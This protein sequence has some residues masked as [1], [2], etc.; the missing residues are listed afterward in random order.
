MD[1]C[2]V[3]RLGIDVFNHDLDA[4]LVH[5]DSAGK[6]REYGRPLHS[7]GQKNLLVAGWRQRQRKGLWPGGT[8]G[9]PQ[10]G[11]RQ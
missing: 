11:H 8:A 1:R 3:G 4:V 9:Q 5:V 7:R 10:Q 6:A 2:P